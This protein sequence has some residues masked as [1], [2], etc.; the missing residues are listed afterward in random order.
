MTASVYFLNRGNGSSPSPKES[1]SY[2]QTE[3]TLPPVSKATEVIRK[4]T[5]Y[6]VTT[7][8]NTLDT[9]CKN[10]FEKDVYTYQYLGQ[11]DA[12]EPTLECS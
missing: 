6:R 10:Y 4:E 1:V 2:I 3:H 12:S 11:T 7:N 5:E 8:P 9:Y